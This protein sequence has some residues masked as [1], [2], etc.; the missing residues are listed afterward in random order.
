MIKFAVGEVKYQDTN[1]NEGEKGILNDNDRV[2][3]GNSNPDFIFGLSQ[4]F[5]Y[6]QFDLSF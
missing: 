4:T 3:V 2:V 6:K 5:R 1:Q